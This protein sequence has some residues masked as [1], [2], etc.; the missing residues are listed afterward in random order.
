MCGG[1]GG[2]I[3]DEEAAQKER[4]KEQQAKATA[5]IADIAL[6]KK[7]RAGGRRSTLL[8]GLGVAETEQQKSL[9]GQ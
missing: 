4:K 9:L 1:G 6:R 8:A 3:T 2:G 5:A 7:V